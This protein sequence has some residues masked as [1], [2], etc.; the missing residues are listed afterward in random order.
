MR[1]DWILEEVAGGDEK[2]PYRLTVERGGRRILEVRTQVRWPGAGTQAFCLRER[3]PD[4][5]RQAGTELERV[6]VRAIERAGPRMSLVLDRPSQKRCDFLLLEKG[7]REQIFWRTELSTK[8]RRPR[9][10]LGARGLFAGL[11]ICVDLRERNA[12]RF[13]P[14]PTEVRSLPAG[15]YGVLDVDGRLVASVERKTLPNLLHELGNLPSLHARLLELEQVPHRAMA[16][17]ARLSDLMKPEK[18]TPYGPDFVMK[19]LAAIQ[20]RHPGLPITFCDNRK[21]AQE[22]TLR[23]LA[24]AWQQVADGRRRP[25]LELPLASVAPERDVDRARASLAGRFGAADVARVLGVRSSAARAC[26][27]AWV[28]D[29]IAVPATPGPRPRRFDW[30]DQ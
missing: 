26:L 2:F 29:G 16:V 4:Y 6:A 28:A 27:Q 10:K 18:T 3:S 14:V 23:F 22:W 11:T 19:C 20:A 1:A 25:Q 24:A 30:K 21:I 8:Q 15:D 17:E 7:G 13:G 12:Y 9:I 5:G